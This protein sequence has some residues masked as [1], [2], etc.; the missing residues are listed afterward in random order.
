MFPY[1]DS[2]KKKKK[3]HKL[4]QFINNTLPNI[5]TKDNHED[6]YEHLICI[7]QA[8]TSRFPLGTKVDVKA[9][10]CDTRGSEAL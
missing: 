3:K 6:Y 10:Q 8:S 5:A 4:E 9:S 7:L 1:L 2:K